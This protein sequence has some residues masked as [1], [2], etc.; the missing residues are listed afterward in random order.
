MLDRELGLESVSWA[1]PTPLAVSYSSARAAR[2][3]PPA[4][5]V[6]GDESGYAL[7]MRVRVRVPAT[8]ANLGPG[9]DALGLALALYNEVTIEEADAL[10]VS[11]EGE[12]AGR[13]D[14]G[15]DNVVARGARLAFEVGRTVRFRGARHPL[16]EPHPAEPRASGRARRHGWA[17]SSGPMRSLGDPI[18]RQGLLALA[19]RARGTP[20]QRRRRGARRAHRVVRR[21]RRP[22]RR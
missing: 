11:I 21:R 4:S 14:A 18:D 22:S 7:A 10:V 2:C 19:A 12:G 9:F 8:S 3:F 17:G 13:L 5:L 1:W 15:G 6:G 16:C 20:R